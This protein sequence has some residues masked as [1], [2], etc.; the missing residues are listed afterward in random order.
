MLIGRT[1][2]LEARMRLALAEQDL[3]LTLRAIMVLRVLVQLAEGE[4]L[5]QTDIVARAASNRSSV[6][7][8]VRKLA[9]LGYIQI[10]R[11]NKED[12]RILQV[13]LTPEGRAHAECIE[14]YYH[15]ACDAFYA[16]LSPDEQQTFE[17]LLAKL[18]GQHDQPYP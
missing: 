10:K 8:E 9:D 12:R 13:S 2:Q 6:S 17:Y 18:L 1:V 7:E 16:N 4:S 14:P 15:T 3:G 5:S 11:D